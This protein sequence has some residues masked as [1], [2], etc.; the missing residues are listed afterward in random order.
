M[1]VHFFNL[2]FNCIYAGFD[3][4][5]IYWIIF[6]AHESS[7]QRTAQVTTQIF[8]IGHIR[9]FILTFLLSK[10]LCALV[11]RGFMCTLVYKCTNIT[12]HIQKCW[13]FVQ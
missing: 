10:I 2:D 7:C 9:I 13:Q 3:K 8:F 5:S 11:Y 6:T 4:T 1:L 12:S